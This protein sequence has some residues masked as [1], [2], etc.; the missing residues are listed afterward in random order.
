MAIRSIASSAQARQ[1]QTAFDCM[2]EDLFNNPE[3]LEWCEVDGKAVSCIAS[4]LTE[5]PSFTPF[6]TD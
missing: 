2:V 1:S 3:L 6:G 4:A 5:S